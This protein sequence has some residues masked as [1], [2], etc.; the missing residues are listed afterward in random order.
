[1]NSVSALPACFFNPSAW[2]FKF[3]CHVSPVVLSS[4]RHLNSVREL[5]YSSLFL[6]YIRYKHKT[7]TKIILKDGFISFLFNNIGALYLSNGSS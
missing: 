4:G 3:R 7:F 2:R 1:M 5:L 6:K